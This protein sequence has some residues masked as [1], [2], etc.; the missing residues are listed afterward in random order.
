[1][2]F[3]ALEIQIYFEIA[4]A[5]GKSLDLHTMLQKALPVYLRKLGCTSGM[6]LRLSQTGSLYQYEPCFSIPRKTDANPF[7]ASVL[8]R[9]PEQFSE[10]ERSAFIQTLPLTGMAQKQH[11]FHVMRLTDFGL[12]ILIKSGAALSSKILYSLR[13]L[14][15]KLADSC[16]ACNQ[17]DMIEKT[18]LQLRYEIEQR[19]TAELKLQHLLDNLEDQVT[20]RT[21]E[22]E[23]S[24]KR[25]KTLF[26]N[27]Q[28]IYFSLNLD[29]IITEISPSVEQR[30]HFSR[31]QLIGR[32]MDFLGFTKAQTKLFLE[33][34]QQHKK[35][36]N[37]YLSIRAKDMSRHHFSLNAIL[38][39]DTN[40]GAL[41][42]VGSLRDITLQRQAEKSK[43]M[44]ENELLHSKK[45]EALGLLA[46]RVA[47]DLNNV[48]SGIVTYPDLLLN[49]IEENSQLRKPI[50]T[51][52]D[53]GEKAAAIV[54]DLLTMARRGVIQK[55]VI[56][57]NQ[58]IQ[59]YLK[60]PEYHRLVHQ[61]QNVAVVTELEN[62]MLNLEGSDLHIKKALMNLML[63]SAE[64]GA[65]KV[66]IS[67]GNAYCE[68]A[69]PWDE[70]T[71]SEDYVYLKVSDNGPGISMEDQKKIFEPFYTSKIMGYSGTGLGMSVVR[72]TVEDH[73]GHITIDSEPFKETSFQLFFPGS[74]RQIKKTKKD[75]SKGIYKANK[76]TV[77]V[78]D[79]SRDQRQIAKAILE[80]LNF[81]VSTA[82]SGEEAIHKI[83]KKAPRI[84]LLDMIMENGMD[85]LET[86]RQ[87]RKLYP[88]QKVI[89]ASGYSET[90][91]VKKALELGVFKYVRKPY[92]LE[93]IGRAIRDCMAHPANTQQ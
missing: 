68:P 60:S 10:K 22:L 86:Y 55:N 84:I 47:H 87:I 14:N 35:L 78:V 82:K 72:G 51:I 24:Q 2:N 63:N 65:T 91:R 46:G 59:E 5:I 81:S 36:L 45:M 77:L 15:K 66:I 48:L 25:Y 7:Y 88:R 67:T 28:D 6:V 83:Q 12:L 93:T 89:I 85:G 90:Q 32:P 9:L 49:I 26:D 64:A 52:R 92:L 33:H 54:Q 76:E 37:Y 30:L 71:R 23:D 11:H 29:G 56:S 1:M 38:T 50:M 16:I 58:I 4:M 70:K 61:H 43:K 40:H 42:V 18:N 3:K 39:D 8:K 13:Q 57:L 53:S 79:D 19:K 75:E 20:D 62:E 73:N 44:L 17:K 41:Q 31:S 34:L 21:R 69:A 27:I 80:S 74:R